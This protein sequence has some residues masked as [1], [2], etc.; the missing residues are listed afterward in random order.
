[1]CGRYRLSRQSQIVT[2]HFDAFSDPEDWIPRYNVAPSQPVSVI[3]QHPTE[4]TRHLSQVRWGLIRSWSKDPSGAA[5]MTIT[6]SKLHT[7]SRPSA[8]R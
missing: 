2:E 8:M 4:S 6:R 5:S 7:H 3:P 1:M